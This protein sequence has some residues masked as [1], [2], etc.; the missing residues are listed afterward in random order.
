MAVQSVQLPSPNADTTEFP[1]LMLKLYKSQP[2]PFVQASEDFTHRPL[3]LFFRLFEPGE[4]SP[5]LSSFHTHFSQGFSGRSWGEVAVSSA[6]LLHR[7]QCVFEL[8]PLKTALQAGIDHIND[9][10][11]TYTLNHSYQ[12][13]SLQCMPRTSG[14]HNAKADTEAF[15]I[16]GKFNSGGF[17]S[18]L[19]IYYFIFKKNYRSVYTVFI[20][21]LLRNFKKAEQGTL[22][23]FACFSCTNTGNKF[24]LSIFFQLLKIKLLTNF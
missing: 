14:M 18:F 13:Q 19:V 16:R 22:F 2:Y 23:Y 17:A 12:L 9:K 11:C 10:T 1:E 3:S 21:I 24:I 4:F 20:K 7:V 6:P 5:R 15:G 8:A